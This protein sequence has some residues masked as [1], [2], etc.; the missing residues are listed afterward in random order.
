M[1]FYSL[2][3]GR[4]I[5]RKV[6]EPIDIFGTDILI[7]L[8]TFFIRSDVF[9]E[10]IKQSVCWRYLTLE[11]CKLSCHLVSLVIG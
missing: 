9:I 6:S 11:V 2:K 10:Y 8:Q 1:S 5:S 4:I 7:T 3:R